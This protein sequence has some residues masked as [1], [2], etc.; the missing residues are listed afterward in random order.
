MDVNAQVAAQNEAKQAVKTPKI[1]LLADITAFKKV[2]D[3]CKTAP[4][5]AEP[6]EIPDLCTNKYNRAVFKYTHRDSLKMDASDLTPAELKA[7]CLRST[8]GSDESKWA[9]CN[10]LPS[11]SEKASKKAF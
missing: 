3:P 11:A 9:K 2:A 4:G 10:E 5:A 1:G 8:P 7:F 6:T